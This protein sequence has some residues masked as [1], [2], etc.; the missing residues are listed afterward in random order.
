MLHSSLAP[1][2]FRMCPNYGGNRQIK[3]GP[4]ALSTAAAQKKRGPHPSLEKV[5]TR[6]THEER[7][8]LDFVFIGVDGLDFLIIVFGV[9]DV[10]NR[11]AID[12][13]A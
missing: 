6:V 7:I 8:T 4:A 5:R 3:L 1:P 10:S 9:L 12:G 2:N 13:T 11:N